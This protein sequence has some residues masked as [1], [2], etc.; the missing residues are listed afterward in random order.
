MGQG[1]SQEYSNMLDQRQP[2]GGGTTSAGLGPKYRADSEPPT[3]SHYGGTQLNA[4]IPEDEELETIS[5]T[6]LATSHLPPN[7][8]A[9]TAD[10]RKASTES[11]ILKEKS[12]AALL[13]AK[14]AQQSSFSTGGAVS[15]SPSLSEG[16]GLNLPKPRDR[17]QSVGGY[18]HFSDFSLFP[19]K[20]GP[21]RAQPLK[22]RHFS[23]GSSEDGKSVPPTPPPTPSTPAIT[24]PLQ[25]VTNAFFRAR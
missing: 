9:A 21:T 17:A 20:F 18:S 19:D 4:M 10:W 11:G 12:L 5:P 7:N 13:E 8:V 24:T 6:N 16:Q 15:H 3:S 22:L 14:A 1:W 2:G 25:S 23:G